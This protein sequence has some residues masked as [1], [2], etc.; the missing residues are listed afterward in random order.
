MMTS[1]KERRDIDRAYDYGANAYLVKP[2][3]TQA[4]ADL[5]KTIYAFWVAWNTSPEVEP[6]NVVQG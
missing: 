1:S 4:F 6:Q 3:E 2:V 5:V